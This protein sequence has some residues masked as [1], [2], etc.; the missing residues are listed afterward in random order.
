MQRLTMTEIVIHRKSTASERSVKTL[1]VCVCV[2]GGGGGGGGG[3]FRG[4][5]PRP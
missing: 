2:G 4:H 1:L 3:G 5:N